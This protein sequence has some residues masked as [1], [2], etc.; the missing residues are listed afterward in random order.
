M[1]RLGAT[2][3]AAKPQIVRNID[4]LLFHTNNWGSIPAELSHFRHSGA[5][6]TARAAVALNMPTAPSDDTIRMPSSLTFPT[7]DAAVGAET[8][9]TAFFGAVLVTQIP[10]AYSEE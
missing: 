1:R 7:V 5:A 10:R 3:T 6:R 8:A 9:D 4:A 2:C